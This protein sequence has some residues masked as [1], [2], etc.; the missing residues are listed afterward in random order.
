M[1]IIMKLL[2]LANTQID[3]NILETEMIVNMEINDFPICLTYWNI[4]QLKCEY[5][6]GSDFISLN[7]IY[8]VH[9]KAF[10]D[11]F[12]NITAAILGVKIATT[13]N[14]STSKSGGFPNNYHLPQNRVDD[15]WFLVKCR[16]SQKHDNFGKIPLGVCR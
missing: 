11:L 9:S 1:S 13:K 7:G 15:L 6:V 14:H 2:I 10:G 5:N 3:C 12:P 8:H 16:N 4:L